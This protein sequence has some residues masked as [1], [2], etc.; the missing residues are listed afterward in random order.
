MSDDYSRVEE[1]KKD[2]KILAVVAMNLGALCF[3]GTNATYRII[4]ADYHA[5]DF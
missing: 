5:A 1:K 2:S 4:A 3:T